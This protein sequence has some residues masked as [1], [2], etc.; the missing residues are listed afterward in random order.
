MWHVFEA[1]CFCFWQEENTSKP[2]RKKLWWS[3]WKHFLIVLFSS[4][5]VFFFY[6]SLLV[7]QTSYVFSYICHD[8]SLYS[9]S[10]LAKIF[11]NIV[12]CWIYIFSSGW[13]GTP[14]SLI[15]S[16]AEGGSSIS[17]IRCM[18]EKLRLSLYYLFGLFAL[19]FDFA[20]RTSRRLKPVRV[21]ASF[22]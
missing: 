14:T 21:G 5:Q 6:V 4:M 16:N 15:K 18:S 17:L 2:N 3:S 1:Y 11:C 9:N 10:S 12:L 20:K 19:A 8:V 22:T 7:E 13:M